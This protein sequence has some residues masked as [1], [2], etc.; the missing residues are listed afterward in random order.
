MSKGAHPAALMAEVRQAVCY[1]FHNVPQVVSKRRLLW[2]VGLR[3]RV[4]GRDSWTYGA[5][6]LP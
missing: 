6:R 2:V 1:P 5:S 4:E 3:K